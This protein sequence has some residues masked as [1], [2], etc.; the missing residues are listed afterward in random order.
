MDDDDM[1]LDR[2]KKAFVRFLETLDRLKAGHCL[3][4]RDSEKLPHGTVYVVESL[5]SSDIKIEMLDAE[6]G[7]AMI[8]EGP[9]RSPVEGYLLGSRTSDGVAKVDEDVYE[10]EKFFLPGQLKRLAVLQYEIG[11]ETRSIDDIWLVKIVLPNGT[12]Y[13]LWDG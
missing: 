12:Q 13:D 4:T 7:R 8:Q 3:D 1:D 9:D 11:G 10:F 5:K 2:A 6:T